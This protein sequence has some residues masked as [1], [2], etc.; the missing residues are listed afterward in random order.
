MAAE[1]AVVLQVVPSAGVSEREC[2][3]SPLDA[4]LLARVSVRWDEVFEPVSLVSS[5][6]DEEVRRGGL[7]GFCFGCRKKNPAK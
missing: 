1:V 2:G 7:Q 6:E 4:G 3:V 5:D